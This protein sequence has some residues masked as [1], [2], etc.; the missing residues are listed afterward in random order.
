[1]AFA[2]PQVRTINEVEGPLT[3]IAFSPDGTRVV[4]TS[5]RRKG[6]VTI[7]DAGSGALLNQ[8]A[9]CDVATW[10]LAYSP[11]SKFIATGSLDSVV[12]I[13][14]ASTLKPLISRTLHAS[15]TAHNT[16][17]NG[18]PAPMRAVHGIESVAFSPD[19][20]STASAGDDGTVRIWDF[21]DELETRADYSAELR[22][23]SASSGRDK[24]RKE[25][26]E[27]KNVR[28]PK[29]MVRPLGRET[30]EVM[31]DVVWDREGRWVASGGTS[32]IIFWDFNTRK[33]SST[34]DF[35]AQCLA[36]SPDGR[37]IAAANIDHD[38]G[39]QVW[40]IA[41]RKT[42]VTLM[43]KKA[44]AFIDFSPD[45][46]RLATVGRWNVQI[47]DAATGHH[48]LELGE[49][50]DDDPNDQVFSMGVRFS[51]DGRRIASV[52]GDLL[53]IWSIADATDSARGPNVAK[54]AASTA[55]A[56]TNQKSHPVNEAAESGASA[57][58]TTRVG[59][60]KL[61]RIPAG[62]FLMGSPKGKGDDDERPQHRIEISRAFFLG[63]YEVTQGQYRDV[64]GQNPSH[65]SSNGGGKE[66]VSGRST[67]QHPVESITWLDAVRFCNELCKREGAKPFYT[68]Q[69]ESVSVADWRETGYR[70]PTE[71]EWEYAC[72]A[73]TQTRHYFDGSVRTDSNGWADYVWIANNSGHRTFDSSD[74]P[75]WD[76]L[77]RDWKK[78]EQ[79]LERRGCRTHPV[80]EKLPNGYGLYDMCG[81]VMEW[82][83]DCYDKDFYRNSPHTDPTGPQAG[84]LRIIRGGGFEIA[85]FQATSVKRW[86]SSAGNRELGFRIARSAALV[87]NTGTHATGT[88]LQGRAAR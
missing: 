15:R 7:R 79:E 36:V 20:R 16:I 87:Q 53:R 68:I 39:I 3:N 17:V 19:S 88:K 59:S 82:C 61:K 9:A 45:G 67:D 60:I 11:D 32:K 66:L 47:W 37:L 21:A 64:I 80:G 73:G 78:V 35:L 18:N 13:W 26:S 70:L 6:P 55:G 72:R 83:W 74:A 27:V 77:G 50:K 51:P 57:F 23:S 43:G 65:F 25:Q 62:R 63:V 49:P 2:T 5:G 8:T 28:P 56:E 30:Q 69:G 12:R 42:V 40:E 71:A 81:N 14:D 46:K 24:L 76:E 58:L 75:S 1:M 86:P 84:V 48:L 54:N 33:E 52:R 34:I 4:T 41:T 10:A 31:R 29:S 38:P 44:I 22:G 85:L